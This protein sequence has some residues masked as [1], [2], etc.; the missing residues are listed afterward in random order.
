VEEK[1]LV[2]VLSAVDLVATAMIVV[3]CVASFPVLGATRLRSRLGIAGDGRPVG[4]MAPAWRLED[5]GAQTHTVPDT[6]KWQLLL[7]T[8]HSIITFPSLIVGLRLLRSQLS[9]TG[10]ILIMSRHPAITRA[11][12]E[13]VDLDLPVIAVDDVFY[14]RYRVRVL[15]FAVAVDPQGVVREVGLVNDENKVLTFWRRAR[16]LT[17]LH[18]PG[19]GVAS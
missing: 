6:R 4:T 13:E 14:R 16:I 3:L 19:A 18:H 11:V 17:A 12:I 8:D 10:K 15:P 1:G 5:M 7:F 9:A 2:A